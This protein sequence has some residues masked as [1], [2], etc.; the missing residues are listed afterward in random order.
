MGRG[1]TIVAAIAIVAVNVFLGALFGLLAGG[2]PGLAGGVFVGLC[3]SVLMLP[4]SG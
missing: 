3:V 1:R 4:R 2:L